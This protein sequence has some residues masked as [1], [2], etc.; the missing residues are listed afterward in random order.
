M[1]HLSN[2]PIPRKL[3]ESVH[4]VKE[5]Q[6]HGFSDASQVAYGAVIYA[7]HLHF[8][9]TVT[10]VLLSAKTRV[11]PVKEQTIPRFELCGARL[12]AKLVFTVTCELNIPSSRLYAWYDSTAVLHWLRSPPNKRSVFEKNRVNTTIELIPATKWR[13]VTTNCNPADLASR[14]TFPKEFLQRKIW[15][16]G[17][18][19]LQDSPVQW[20]I[21]GDIGD[22]PV[23]VEDFEPVLTVQST[24]HEPEELL[25]HSSLNRLVRFW[26]YARRW[27]P[28]AKK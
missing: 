19:W 23:E 11:A 15:W 21:R 26:A 28:Q 22:P 7:R 13:N 5:I 10:T 17:P 6:L 2:F 24:E 14:G 27:I 3:V 18:P 8:N 12:L 9:A 1:P 16:T 20:P 25:R 4:T